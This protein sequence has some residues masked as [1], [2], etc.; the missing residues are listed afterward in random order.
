MNSVRDPLVDER[1]RKGTRRTIIDSRGVWCPPTPLTDLFKAWR[2]A[3]IGD[4]IELRA[5]E[6]GVEKDVRDWAAKSGN[7]LVLCSQE[8]DYVKVV[9]R[10]TRKGKR[11]LEES[12]SKKSFSEPDETKET[13]KAQLRMVRLGGF[14]MGLRT[15]EAG[16]RWS[17]DIK[18]LAGT[19]LCETRH[20]G[21]VLSGSMGFRM[22]DGTEL[23]VNAG[24]AFDVYPGH[25]AWTVGPEPVV[26]LDLIGAVENSRSD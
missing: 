23:E 14:S 13:P 3:R 1:E 5:T 4:L 18:P 10:I 2:E 26:F 21:Y 7:R 9:V 17:S 20:I 19:P 25:D 12:A 11:I 15:L 6:P 8:K 24:D 16:W 22:D